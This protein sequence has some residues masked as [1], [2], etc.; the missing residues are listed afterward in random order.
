MESRNTTAL[1]SLALFAAALVYAGAVVYG[2]VMFI[3]VM[4]DAFPPGILGGLAIVGAITT[5]ASALILPVALHFWFAPG[6]QFV[7]GILFWLLDIAVLALNSML[8]FAVATGSGMLAMWGGF[9]P[10]TP[11]LAVL[12]WGVI[13]LLDPSH[14]LRHAQLELESDLIDIHTEQL[15]QAAKDVG[16][17]AT[18]TNGARLRAADMAALLTGIRTPVA[19]N[20]G[21]PKDDPAQLPAQTEPIASTNGRV[22]ESETEM[23]ANP[24]P[25]RRSKS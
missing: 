13:F 15:R 12:G 24:T 21:K 18:I 8:A 7:A 25:R 9:A 22:Y 14:K 10:A 2:D 4:Q 17:S 6:T 5:A 16:V 11:L 23:L 3:A 1:K 19:K 20:A